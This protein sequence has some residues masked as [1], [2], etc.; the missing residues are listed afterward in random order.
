MKRAL[1]CFALI[2]IAL[3]S[4]KK[5]NHTKTNSD[6]KTYPVTFSISNFNQENNPIDQTSKSKVNAAVTPDQ[7]SVLK[8]IYKLYDSNN[9]LKK[10]VIIKKGAPGFGVVKDSLASGNYTAVFVGLID[11]LNFPYYSYSELNFTYFNSLNDL[12]TFKETFYKKTSFVVGSDLLQQA[13]VLGR[14]TSELQII[15]KDAIPAGVSQFQIAINGV[16]VEYSY[17]DDNSSHP[18][19]NSYSIN[20]PSSAIGT[21]NYTVGPI[22]D[23]LNT[24]SPLTVTIAAQ[25]SNG[26][27]FGQK[28]ISNIML[29]RNTRTI[30]TGNL[31]SSDNA[32]GNGFSV[33]YNPAY[34]S[35]GI[36]QGF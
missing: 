29:Q 8:L 6:N 9:Q 26:I 32:G 17:F 36:N 35:T 22:K 27:Y 18:T 28:T 10:T 14:I 19:R 21:T 13:V 7:S 25:N 11:T 23:L 16:H 31:F 5:D 34:N 2:T 15:I 20:V 24:N 12:P 33:T 1:I 3:F 4:C 30:L